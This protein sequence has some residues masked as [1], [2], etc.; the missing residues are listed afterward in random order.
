[1]IPITTIVPSFALA[2]L[3]PAFAALYLFPRLR[4][5]HSKYL[6][7][8]AVGIAL[9]FFLDTMGDALYLDAYCCSLYPPYLFGGIGHFALIGA[10]VLGFAVLA[11]FDRFAVPAD[12]PAEASAPGSARQSIPFLIPVAVAAVMG[13]HGLGEGWISVSPVSSGPVASV[14]FLQAL[15]TTYGDFP[16]LV[17]YPVHKFLEASVVGILYT[18]YVTRTAGAVKEKWWQIPLLGLLFAGPSVVG[19]I[20]GYYV[21]FDTSYLF[22]FGVTSAFYAILRLAGLIG[23]DKPGGLGPAHFGTGT[24]VALALGFLLLYS[25]A[26]LH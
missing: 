14:G 16:A 10:F 5:V 20:A 17:S 22:A 6:A 7:A 13:I 25:A 18:L 4:S 9:W 2:T 19:S 23:S 26:L 3:V 24:F 8:A 1:M 21:P 15:I 12:L 11:I